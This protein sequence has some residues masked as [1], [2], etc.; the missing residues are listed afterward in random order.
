[1]VGHGKRVGEAAEFQEPGEPEA[2]SA[3]R[4][5]LHRGPVAP[6]AAAAGAAARAGRSLYWEN[7]STTAMEGVSMDT[8]SCGKTTVLRFS[9]RRDATTYNGRRK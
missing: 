1:M 3:M 5:Q 8:P 9:R 6:G 4:G 7:L 2:R